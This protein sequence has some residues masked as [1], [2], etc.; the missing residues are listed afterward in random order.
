MEVTHLNQFELAKRWRM[1]QRTLEKWRWEGI[2]P[3][4]VKIG[5]MRVVYRLADIEAFEKR[6]ERIP[7]GNQGTGATAEMAGAQ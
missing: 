4:Y 6:G 1:S 5:G 2:G 3:T 7:E